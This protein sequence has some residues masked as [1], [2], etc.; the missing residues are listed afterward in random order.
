MSDAKRMY[1]EIEA[2]LVDLHN[3]EARIRQALALLRRETEAG[4]RETK[5]A[6]PQETKDAVDG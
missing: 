2:A 3:V 5:P 1:A 6:G 4:R